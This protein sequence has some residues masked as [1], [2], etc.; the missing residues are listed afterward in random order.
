M[1]FKLKSF[2]FID[3][4]ELLSNFIE[5]FFQSNENEFFCESI[6]SHSSDIN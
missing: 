2:M 3:S 1:S 5:I 6:S 4:V